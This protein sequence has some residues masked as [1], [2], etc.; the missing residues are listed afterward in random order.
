MQ[1]PEISN[2]RATLLLRLLIVDT[3]AFEDILSQ[4][5]DGENQRESR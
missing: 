4:Y 2:V 1:A 5:L 3:R